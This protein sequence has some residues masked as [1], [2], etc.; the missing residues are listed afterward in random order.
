MIVTRLILDNW[1][2]HAH[3]DIEFSGRSNGILGRNGIGKS[4]FTKA[5]RV[6]ITGRTDSGSTLSDEIKDGETVARIELHFIHDGVEGVIKRRFYHVSTNHADITWGETS[7][8]G[9]TETNTQIELITGVT[10][11]TI[12]R[13]SFVEQDAL[14]AILFDSP[15]KRVEQI[16]SMIPEIAKTR[17]YR[18]RVAGF[19]K[20]IP[21]INLPYDRDHVLGRIEAFDTEAVTAATEYGGLMAQLAGLGDTEAAQNTMNDHAL[22]TAAILQIDSLSARITE[23]TE[24]SVSLLDSATAAASEIEDISGVPEDFNQEEALAKV[25]AYNKFDFDRYES[26]LHVTQSEKGQKAV[27]K[28]SREVAK[29]EKALRDTLDTRAALEQQLAVQTASLG[30]DQEELS[31]LSMMGTKATCPTCKGP[32]D[33]E[34]LDQRMEVLTSDVGDKTL[35]IGTTNGLLDGTKLQEVA[36]IADKKL[37]EVLLTAKQTFILESVAFVKAAV[38]PEVT[39]DQAVT[40]GAHIDALHRFKTTTEAYNAARTASTAADEALIALTVEKAGFADNFREV[41]DAEAAAASKVIADKVILDLE[42][43]RKQVTMQTATD[44]GEKFREMLVEV[45]KAIEDRAS[46]DAYRETVTSVKDLMHRDQL[47]KVVLRYYLKDM[48]EKLN[49]YLDA[50]SVPFVVNISEDFDMTF[51]KEGGTE[52]SLN[53]LSGGEK[54]VVSVSMHL[55]VSDMFAGGLSMLVLDE[56]SQNMDPEYVTMLTNVIETM[57]SGVLGGDRQL[58]VVTHHKPEMLGAFDKVIELT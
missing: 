33:R 6:A 51:V 54:S 32:I 3:R 10:T 29:S 35:Q 18:D 43:A 5:I 56:P 42:I 23:A 47:P 52:K 16:I 13:F 9:I 7:V 48:R 36:L 34:S 20:T 8:K 22:H 15:G 2:Q 37:K 41:T 44:E 27:E 19:L 38:V 25:Y 12:E 49:F 40:L 55:A 26:H 58:I 39:Y 24:K 4:N 28:A 31:G 30:V 50:F 45:D 14:R 11:E 1:C 53:R 17:L 57:S 46:V 21:E